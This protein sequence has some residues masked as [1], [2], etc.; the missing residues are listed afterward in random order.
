[1]IEAPSLTVTPGSSGSFDLLLVNTNPTGG[2]SYDLAG[3]QF[4]LTVSGPLGIT[5]TDASIDTDPVAAPYIFVTSG[6]TQGGGP[7]SLD[8]FPNT[9]FTGLDTEFANPGFRTLNPGDVFGLAHVSF[10]VSSSA[11]N[12]TDMLT[13]SPSPDSLLIDSNLNEIPFGI[14]N[15]SFRIGSAIPEPW[16]LTQATTAAVIGL[17][18]VWRRGRRCQGQ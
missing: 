7:L 2:D 9:S 18:L 3:D 16:A 8:P 15:G 13:I 17:G 5:F 6:T 4:V 11:P 14:L 10:S 1:M 12:G